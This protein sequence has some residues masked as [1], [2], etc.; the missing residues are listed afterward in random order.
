MYKALL[1]CASVGLILLCNSCNKTEESLTL[2]TESFNLADSTTYANLRLEIELPVVSDKITMSIREKLLEKLGNRLT[3]VTSYEN[4]QLYLPFQGD[5][6]NTKTML[7]Y[8]LKNT[9]DL[10]G[11]QS[12][13]DANDRIKFLR[14]N[15]DLTEEEINELKRLL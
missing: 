8:Y 10:L 2:Q 6:H 9:R 7:D 3:H 11:K 12:E 14:E 1:F 15:K 4:E 5:T 13:E